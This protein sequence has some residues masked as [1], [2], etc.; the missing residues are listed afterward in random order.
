M[1]DTVVAHHDYE[2]QQDD[3]LSFVA[4]DIIKVTDHSNTDWWLGTK[5]DGSSGYFPSNFVD[6]AVEKDDNKVTSTPIT[7][8]QE[9]KQ[10]TTVA[11]DVATEQKDEIKEPQQQQSIGMARVMEDYAMQEDDE[12]TLHKGGIVVLYERSDDGVWLKGEINGKQGRFPAKYVEDIDMPGRPDLGVGH[13]EST[14]G[15]STEGTSKAGPPGGFKLAAFGVK[16]GGIGSV[17]A[18]GFPTLKKTSTSAPKAPTNDHEETSTTTTT[19]PTAQPTDQTINEPMAKATLGKAI[20]LH[21]YNAENQDELNLIRG[22]YIEILDRNADEGWWEGRNEKNQT[23]VFPSNFVKEIEHDQQAPPPPV[24]S[25][26]SVA[27]VG[28]ATASPIIPSESRP[29]STPASSLQRSDLSSRVVP[30]PIQRLPPLPDSQPNPVTSPTASSSEGHQNDNE[31]E[32]ET[33]KSSK[34]EKEK[35]SPITPTIT[36]NQKTNHGDNDSFEFEGN[37]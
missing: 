30:P 18:G 31:D 28:A 24:R 35:P 23:G 5:Q 33:I 29:F 36:E 16:Q 10:P 2:A 1:T 14:S 15:D 7:T 6:A 22:E 8:E 12:L 34:D 11:N 20:V 26:K 9:P 19:Q 37:N 3:E 25:R 13:G 27:S 4:G 21:P 32:K 17:L